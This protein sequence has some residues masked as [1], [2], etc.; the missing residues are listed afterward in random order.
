MEAELS[1]REPSGQG[2]FP[3]FS[4]FFFAPVYLLQIGEEFDFPTGQRCKPGSTP[5]IESNDGIKSF[6]VAK[7]ASSFGLR[8]ATHCFIDFVKTHQSLRCQLKPAMRKT[9]EWSP[10]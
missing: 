10:G 9:F 5:I 1:Q 6:R 3:N 8:L 7:N 4:N 2:G